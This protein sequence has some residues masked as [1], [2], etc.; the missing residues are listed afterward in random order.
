[1]AEFVQ[2]TSGGVRPSADGGIRDVVRGLNIHLLVTNALERHVI[3]VHLAIDNKQWI[4]LR[5]HVLIDTDPIKELLED[6]SQLQVL[7]PQALALLFYS[8]VVNLH[9]VV[10]LEELVKVG[11]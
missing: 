8:K 4:R 10:T 9:L 3:Q 6:R 11:P 1:M 2:A 5:Q 7:L